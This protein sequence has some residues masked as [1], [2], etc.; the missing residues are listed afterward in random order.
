MQDL[1]NRIFT[2]ISNHPS[3][4]W[5][6]AQLAAALEYADEVVDVRFPAVGPMLDT[7]DVEGLA[8]ALM[9]RLPEN[10]V[11]AMVSGEFV[12][13]ACLIKR[14]QSVGIPCFAATTVRKV[15]EDG[16]LKTT[17][18]NFVRFREY[19]ELGCK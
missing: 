16:D 19:P 7:D 3:E 12:L 2:N 13:T 6:D 11:A 5:Q 17:V 9:A 15:I 4:R 14:L 1:K 10:T 18:F 8:D